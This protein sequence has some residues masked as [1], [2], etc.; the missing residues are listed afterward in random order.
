MKSS[1][2]ETKLSCHATFWQGKKAKE[3]NQTITSSIWSEKTGIPC[4][5]SNMN[6][7]QVYGNEL[8]GTQQEMG[9]NM[10]INLFLGWR[11]LYCCC[12]PGTNSWDFACSAE[13][14]GLVRISAFVI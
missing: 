1:C 8:Y 12:F 5:I 3:A 11:F 7:R 10:L 6:V 2:I 4:Q 14:S 9:R 13:D